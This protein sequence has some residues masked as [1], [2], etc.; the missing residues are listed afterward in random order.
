[1]GLFYNR[2]GNFEKTKIADYVCKF[3]SVDRFVQKIIDSFDCPFAI[4]NVN[5]FE[6]EVTNSKDFFPGMKC[7]DLFKCMDGKC[8][9]EKCPLKKVVSF[10]KAVIDRDNNSGSGSYEVHAHPI[11]NPKGDVESAIVYVID[12]SQSEALI[13]SEE[14]FKALSDVLFDGV[15][16]TCG[17]KILEMNEGFL[18]ATGYE[19]KDLAGKDVDFLVVPK[20]RAKVMRHIKEAYNEPYEHRM[21]RKDGTVIDVEV[22]GKSA[23]YKGKNC[24]ITA[25]RDITAKKRAEIALREKEELRV[26]E[27]EERF[28]NIL[29]NSQD[30]VYRYD[31]RT[32]K[33]DYVSESVFTILGYPLEEFVKM[34]M[35]DYNKR[36]HS[37]DVEAV[38]K[39][40]DA[41][42]G[43]SVSVIE[44]RFK[45][46]GSNYIW[47]KA[48]RVFFRNEKGELLYSIE[49][50]KDITKL[51]LGE[52]EKARLK[53][54][55]IQ[56]RSSAL[57]KQK[58]ISLT[59]KE[60]L[61]F[62]GIC[63]YP[64]LKDE[65]LATKLNLKRST[66]TSIK[67][68]LKGDWFNIKYIPNFYKLGCQFFSIFDASFKSGKMKSLDLIREAPGVV[69]G[70]CQDDK[71]FTGFT[72]DKYVDF[73][74]LMEQVCEDDALIG[75]LNESSFFYNLNNFFFYDV[76]ALINSVFGLKKKE[77]P[78]VYQF[79]N[80]AL[81]EL[82]IN[83]KRVLHA[84]V[85]DSEMSSSDIAKKIWISKP[86]V[87]KI[88]K[89]LLKE[90]Y[91]YPY[92]V[93]DFRKLGFSYFARFSLEFDSDLSEINGKE[94]HDARTIIRVEG[95]RK[96]TKIILFTSEE[97][98]EEKVAL[99]REIYR[100][101]GVGFKLNS[102][103]FP[104]QKRWF[105]NSKI[106][107]FVN[108]R[109]FGAEL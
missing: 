86:T 84:A 58:R 49:D 13:E 59:D 81:D 36:I 16:I 99:I 56:I 71:L 15:G 5:S 90:N 31:F 38:K 94:P 14:R 35:N 43:E 102:K 57:E 42:E 93:P 41:I 4:V 70:N 69:F 9:G 89:K 46:K 52:E 107:S 30:L 103:I 3:D 61:V 87:I 91:V 21:M 11:I 67:N 109:L 24:R 85:K 72:S 82:N 40:E 47:L 39:I 74:G 100:K 108:D 19:M 79:K 22:S 32:D 63:R 104:I 105:K 96:I 80:G 83:E 75:N 1:M 27:V 44:Y 26:V 28:Y 8:G 20:D 45:K 23:H 77:S 12:V 78:A 98:Y 92:A 2:Y 53:E 7:R 97:E 25:I 55:L 65:D 66:L 48:Q 73:R 10:K 95:K 34:K 33:F 17:G 50:I 60:K 88:K 76:S 62:W 64:T 6:V 51:R 18:R 106:E 37:E 68:R 101:K 29:Q 54:R